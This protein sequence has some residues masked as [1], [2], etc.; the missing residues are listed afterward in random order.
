MVAVRAKSAR[1]FLLSSGR[2]PQKSSLCDQTFVLQTVVR[3]EGNIPQQN[4]SKT[5]RRIPRLAMD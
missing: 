2:F 3:E 5:K 1:G 4:P